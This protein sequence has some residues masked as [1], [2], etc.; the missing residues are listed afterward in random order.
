MRNIIE[1]KDIKDNNNF[2]LLFLI[3]NFPE[4]LNNETD[5][6]ISEMVSSNYDIDKEWVD[7]F[8]GYYEEVFDEND[9]YIENP[10]TLKVQLSTHDYLF[11]EFHPGDTIYF[12]NEKEIGCTGPEYSIHKINWEKFCEYTKT[13]NVGEKMLLLPMLFIEGEEQKE[14]REMV[15][16]GLKVAK[17]RENDFESLY[18]AIMENCLIR[19]D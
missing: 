8:V 13:L 4:S 1:Y 18:N 17:I 14:L 10:T 12:V 9:G 11:I 16:E 6:T 15:Y 3:N 19:M 2:W 7:N 5:K